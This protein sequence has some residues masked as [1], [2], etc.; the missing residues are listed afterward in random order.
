MKQR[1]LHVGAFAG[2]VLFVLCNVILVRGFRWNLAERP[3]VSYWLAVNGRA[4]SWVRMTVDDVD[5]Q[6]IPSHFRDRIT[7]GRTEAE[8]RRDSL[9]DFA[10]YMRAEECAD[11]LGP[12]FRGTLGFSGSPTDGV[13]QPDAHVLLF[14]VWILHAACSVL[15]LPLIAI[16]FETLRGFRRRRLRLCIRCA[17]SLEGN[18]SG[19]CTECGCRV[20][21]RSPM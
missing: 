19:V 7:E 8:F 1:I 15:L 14:P 2:V 12:Y 18:L 16:A 4:C 13:P 20:A 11:V 3:G 5:F 17:Y 6:N 9:R 21:A 10:K